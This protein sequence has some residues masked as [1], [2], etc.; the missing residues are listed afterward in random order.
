MRLAQSPSRTTRP[1]W[2][3]GLMTRLSRSGIR[4][5][6]PACRRLTL[7]ERSIISHLMLLAHIYV[8][9]SVLLPLVCY[10][11]PTQQILWSVIVPSVMVEELVRMTNGLH[12]IP[13][14][15]FGCHQSIGRPS[16]QYQEIMLESGLDLVEYGYVVSR[17]MSMKFDNGRDRRASRTFN[18]AG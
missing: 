3:L 8:L 13:R 7:I 18:K 5:V 12:I 1:G 9:K 11:F 16:P 15:R 2:H 14:I 6:A 17:T 4:A 10:Q